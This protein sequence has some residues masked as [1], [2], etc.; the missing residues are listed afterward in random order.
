MAMQPEIGL[1][2]RKALR[3]KAARE[4]REAEHES[5]LRT[6]A[7]PWTTFET[8]QDSKELERRAMAELGVVYLASLGITDEPTD[9]QTVAL[10]ELSLEGLTDGQL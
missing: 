4:R 8:L 5:A 2:V 1:A 6:R 3:A 9:A 10:L 7:R